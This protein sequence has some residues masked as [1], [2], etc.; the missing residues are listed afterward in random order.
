[1]LI[2]NV[3]YSELP[4][5]ITRELLPDGTERLILRRNITNQE[6]EEGTVYTA[7]EAVMV[8]D[9]GDTLDDEDIAEDF[10]GCFEYAANWQPPKTPTLEELAA[11]VK[12]IE[13]KEG[14]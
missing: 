10:G 6:N 5:E 13:I 3:Q 11:R 4:N 14:L 9:Q 1:M 7:D 2:F 8:A 12:Y